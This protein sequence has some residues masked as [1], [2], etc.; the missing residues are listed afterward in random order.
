MTDL[1]VVLDT[2]EKLIFFEKRYGCDQFGKSARILL[3]N[4]DLKSAIRN[5]KVKDS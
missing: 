3:D 2:M 4:D 1:E 5:L